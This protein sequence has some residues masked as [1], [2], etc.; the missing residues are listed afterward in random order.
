[1][2]SCPLPDQLHAYFS[3]SSVQ[4]PE[5]KRLVQAFIQ[6]FPVPSTPEPHIRTRRS[7]SVEPVP[8]PAEG[9]TNKELLDNNIQASLESLS[10]ALRTLLI[11]ESSWR[12]GLALVFSCTPPSICHV[13]GPLAGLHWVQARSSAYKSSFDREAFPPS[14][15]LRILMEI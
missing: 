8:Y 3:A 1:M 4:N 15:D 9:L 14:Q 2:C 13:V 11:G 6:D 5:A 7:A 12:P 10:A